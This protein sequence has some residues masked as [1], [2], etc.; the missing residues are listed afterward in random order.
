MR[1]LW[2]GRGLVDRSCGEGRQSPNNEILAFVRYESPRNNGL[3]SFLHIA[4]CLSC[5]LV[6]EVREWRA[7]EIS[8]LFFVLHDQFLAMPS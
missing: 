3:R 7:G 1:H 6:S 2:G 8:C 5:S 4:F